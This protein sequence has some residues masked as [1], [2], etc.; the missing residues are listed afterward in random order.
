MTM[1]GVATARKR[2]DGSLPDEPPRLDPPAPSPTPRS[3]LAPLRLLEG[4]QTNFYALIDGAVHTA[5]EGVLKGTVRRLLFEVCEREGIPVVL[6]APS[7]EGAGGWEGAML[8]S[9]SRLLLPI[10]ELYV[11]KAGKRS[12]PSDL[13]RR[14]ENK[15]SLAARLRALVAS[16]VEAHSCEI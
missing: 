11:P 6:S 3:A 10:D 5:D 4:S 16:E 7:L 12:A 15:N 1:A 2:A 14:F 8:S 9:T 13:L